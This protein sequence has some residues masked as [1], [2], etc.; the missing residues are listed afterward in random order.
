MSETSREQ[1][2]QQRLASGKHTR[3]TELDQSPCLN[4]VPDIA[5]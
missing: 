4:D 3:P 5:V 1:D 2:A